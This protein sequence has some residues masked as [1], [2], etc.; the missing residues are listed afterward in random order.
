MLVRNSEDRIFWYPG[1]RGVPET[2]TV[3][4]SLE[5]IKAF[6]IQIIS[7]AEASTPN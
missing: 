3:V 7:E 1:K 6:T 4:F 5:T 2:T